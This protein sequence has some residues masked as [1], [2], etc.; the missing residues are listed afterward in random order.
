MGHREQQCE[1]SSSERRRLRVL[2]LLIEDHRS[3]HLLRLAI[4]VA[5][6]HLGRQEENEGQWQ[7][8]MPAV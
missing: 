1:W 7:Q 6:Q 8:G 4:L 3:A 5:P 2:A